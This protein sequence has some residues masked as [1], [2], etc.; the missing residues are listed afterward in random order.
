MKP[1]TVIK[2]NISAFKYYLKGFFSILV[3][4]F[5]SCTATATL[6]LTLIR[7][8]SVSGT[9]LLVSR[10]GCRNKRNS[11]SRNFL[12]VH[13]PQP[14]RSPKCVLFLLLLYLHIRICS[15]LV[16][17]CCGVRWCTL[18]TV[19]KSWND[20]AH[21]S[22][23]VQPTGARCSRGKESIKWTPTNNFTS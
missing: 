17:S 7:G 3:W 18:F 15:L 22:I 1:K 20:L 23:S 12:T 13:F 6:V 21:V 14:I 10:R 4:L 11:V 2:P 5:P 16:Q 9:T 19:R 8:Y